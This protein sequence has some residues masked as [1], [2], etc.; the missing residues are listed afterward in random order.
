MHQLV[1]IRHGES[2][3]NQENRFG[4]GNAS[5]VGL[6]RE[7]ELFLEYLGGKGVAIDLAHPSDALAHDILNYIDKKSLKVTPIASHSN[8]RVIKDKK[9]GPFNFS[10]LR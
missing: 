2:I 9:S 4:G 3:W 8:F 10:P 1:L 5:D 7:G 6:K